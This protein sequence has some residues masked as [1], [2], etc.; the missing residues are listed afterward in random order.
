MGRAERV[1][2]VILSTDL[3]FGSRD[4]LIGIKRC[5]LK[6]HIDQLKV[7]IRATSSVSV[8]LLLIKSMFETENLR[9][10]L[11]S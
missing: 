3:S 5:F 10:D 4:E 1:K 6:C 9:E 2:S 8:I 7:V 11:Q